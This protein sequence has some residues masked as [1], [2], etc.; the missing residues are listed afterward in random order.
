MSSRSNIA[1]AVAW[2]ITAGVV[3]IGIA[4]A[5]HQLTVLY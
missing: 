4:E 2:V 5:L 3:V 1:L